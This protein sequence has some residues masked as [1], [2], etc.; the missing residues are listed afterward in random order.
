MPEWRPEW[1]NITSLAQSSPK[2]PAVLLMTGAMNPIHLGHIAMLNS[3]ISTLNKTS[4]Y[5][6]VQ[7]YVSPSHIQYINKKFNDNTNEVCLSSP[8][9]LEL[10]RLAVTGHNLNN[11]ISVSTWETN[12]P[13][14][15]AQHPSS[16]SI[17]SPISSSNAVTPTAASR[18]S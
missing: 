12:Y 16:V 6:V 4:Q 8:F 13:P 3:A 11:I 2:T 18:G 7:A 9:R 15:S 14:S 1:P 17:I 5:E 10:A